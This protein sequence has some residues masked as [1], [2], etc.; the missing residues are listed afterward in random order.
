MYKLENEIGDS[1]EILTRGY[2]DKAV[3]SSL[4][5]LYLFPDKSPVSKHTGANLKFD[6]PR[7]SY[8]LFI[9]QLVYLH[10]D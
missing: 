6:F 8:K 2:I 3:S 10:S 9:M 7:K 1:F 4:S 5:K